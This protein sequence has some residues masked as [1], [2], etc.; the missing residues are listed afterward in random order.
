MWSQQ[1][2]NMNP[3]AQERS[4]GLREMHIPHIEGGLTRLSKTARCAGR[5]QKRVTLTQ[6][7]LKIVANRGL[8]RA[9]LNHKI[10]QEPPP[11]LR[12]TFN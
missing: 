10:I 11:H 9:E 1:L 2:R 6:N 12:L 7:P 4:R 5:L 3:V 8:I